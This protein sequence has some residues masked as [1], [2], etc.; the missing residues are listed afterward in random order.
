MGSAAESDRALGDTLLAAKRTVAIIPRIFPSRPFF[1]LRWFGPDRGE[2][3]ATPEYLQLRPVGRP[4]PPLVLKEY[5]LPSM[6]VLLV[7]P[8]R[9]RNLTSHSIC[10]FVFFCKLDL[11]VSFTYF[12]VSPP[13]VTLPLESLK[14]RGTLRTSIFSPNALQLLLIYLFIYLFISAAK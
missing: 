6:A 2:L 1:L 13:F 9:C 14:K 5:A 12:D 11:F 4:A 7:S 8:F 3:E 10:C